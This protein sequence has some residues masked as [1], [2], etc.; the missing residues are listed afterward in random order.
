MFFLLAELRNIVLLK[1]V[2]E[3]LNVSEIHEHHF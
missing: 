3:Y 1:L 2:F